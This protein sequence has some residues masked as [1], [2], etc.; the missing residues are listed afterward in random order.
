[1]PLLGQ[2]KS[3]ITEIFWKII[4]LLQVSCCTF[5][6]YYTMKLITT[7]L[8]WLNIC[9]MF[10][11]NPSNE[12]RIRQVLLVLPFCNPPLPKSVYVIYEWFQSGVSMWK[13][14]EWM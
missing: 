13:R 8:H 7:H 5:G 14:R 12:I 10:L 11:K 4:L 9:G 6:G 2:G 1:M 3:S